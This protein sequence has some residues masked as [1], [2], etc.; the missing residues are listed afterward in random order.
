LYHSTITAIAEHT[1]QIIFTSSF[2]KLYSSR[3][4]VDGVADP[5][6]T[7]TKPDRE[8][9]WI[10]VRPSQPKPP[11]IIVSEEAVFL[12]NVPILLKECFHKDQL[13][14]VCKSSGQVE[15]AATKE[16]AS[17]QACSAL[18]I[19]VW[20]ECELLCSLRYTSS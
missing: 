2:K 5:Q 1:T 13:H 20:W 17:A 3:S 16:E 12:F 10:T 6:K 15:G 4:F 7:L 18:P 19:L 11:P 8:E 14:Y 9:S